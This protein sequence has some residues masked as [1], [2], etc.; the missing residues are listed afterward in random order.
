V[1][2]E[3]HIPVVRIMALVKLSV[4]FVAAR[5]ENGIRLDLVVDK[6]SRHV[7]I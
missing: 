7:S 5:F 1:C 6:V 2:V 3:E 4:L